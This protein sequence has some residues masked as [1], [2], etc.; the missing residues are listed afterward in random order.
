MGNFVNPGFFC[1]YHH[2]PLPKAFFAF[3]VGYMMTAQLVC[4]SGDTAK[5]KW[6]QTIAVPTF[7]TGSKLAALTFVDLGAFFHLGLVRV[8]ISTFEIQ[9]TT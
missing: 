3:V 9:F 1:I 4:C 5:P 2:V 7:R 6:V 8:Q